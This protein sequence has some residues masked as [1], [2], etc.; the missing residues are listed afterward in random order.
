MALTNQSDLLAFFSPRRVNLKISINSRLTTSR[1]RS[2]PEDGFRLLVSSNPLLRF[3]L[4]VKQGCVVANLGQSSS[5]IWPFSVSYLLGF[6]LPQEVIFRDLASLSKS[7]SGIWPFSVSHFP[8]FGLPQEVIFR[9][10][11]ILSKSS[12]GI[13]PFSVSHLL[14]P[15]RFL[16]LLS[17]DWKTPGTHFDWTR[18]SQ[19]S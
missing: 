5:G 7:S 16:N 14:G 13:W 9:D 10:L 19:K 17:G 3:Q 8:G 2:S 6:G 11:A 12:S 4:V 1:N 18:P 15:G